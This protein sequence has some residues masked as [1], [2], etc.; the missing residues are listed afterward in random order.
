MA[1]FWYEYGNAL[2]AKEEEN[3]SDDLLGVATREAKAAAGQKF[4][5]ILL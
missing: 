1:E 5:T 4:I 3:P 2:L